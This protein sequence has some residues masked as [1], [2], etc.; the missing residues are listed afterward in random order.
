MLLHYFGKIKK[1]NLLQFTE[2]DFRN[3]I[4]FDRIRNILCHGWAHW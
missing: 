2:V 1:P 3:N 4:I